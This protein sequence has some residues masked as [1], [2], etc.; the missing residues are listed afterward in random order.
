[1]KN[2]TQR[3]IH[4]FFFSHYFGFVFFRKISSEGMRQP[5]I[6]KMREKKIIEEKLR[7]S[8]GYSTVSLEIFICF[9]K[10]FLFKYKIITLSVMQDSSHLTII[11]CSS[12]IIIVIS[13]KYTKLFEK[14]KLT[15]I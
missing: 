5:T 6:H 8:K 4:K 15:I 3:R 7:K 9:F 10:L 12:V 14:T 11:L 1:M 13:H 2:K